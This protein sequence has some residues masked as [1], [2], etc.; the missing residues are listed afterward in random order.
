MIAPKFKI[1]HVEDDEADR[2]AFSRACRAQTREIEL[3]TMHDGE[4]ALAWMAK[5]NFPNLI[6]LDLDLP[7]QSGLELLST[8]KTQ[9]EGFDIPIVVLSGSLDRNDLR[10]CYDKHAACFLPKPSDPPEFQR[11]LRHFLDFWVDDAQ[12]PLAQGASV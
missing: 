7:G 9:T 8:L 4:A 12:T 5:G 3:E 10:Q 2:E 6:V 1:L 11:V